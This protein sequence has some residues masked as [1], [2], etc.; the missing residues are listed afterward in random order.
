MLKD[1][2]LVQ[3]GGFNVYN[4]PKD[5]EVDF[6]DGRYICSVKKEGTNPQYAVFKNEATGEAVLAFN[7]T[8]VNEGDDLRTDFHLGG[9]GVPPMHE[10]AL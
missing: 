8:D 4:T 9:K 7:G 1:N 3:I 6:N 2:E 5:E 10:Q